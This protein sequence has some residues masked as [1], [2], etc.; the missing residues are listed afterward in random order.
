[1][2]GSEVGRIYDFTKPEDRRAALETAA[3]NFEMFWGP[4]GEKAAPGALLQETAARDAA[5][6]REIAKHV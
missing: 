6:L 2:A 5:A 1:M 4:L 3:R